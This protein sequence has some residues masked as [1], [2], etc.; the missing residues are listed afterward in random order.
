MGL[1]AQGQDAPGTPSM[2]HPH[3]TQREHIGMAAD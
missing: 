2:G 3:G 1:M